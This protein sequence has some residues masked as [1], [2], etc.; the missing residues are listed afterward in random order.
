MSISGG[1]YR[2]FER[3][4][5]TGCT[6]M[7]VFTKNNS[8]WEARPYTPG[9]IEQYRLAAARS[10]V[11]PVLAHAAYLINLCAAVPDVLKKSRA[12]LQ[13]EL[14][15]CEALGILGLI[16]HPGSHVGTGEKEGIKRIAESLNVVHANT[17]KYRTRSILETTAGQ[18]SAVGYRFEQLSG[19]IDYVDEK[20]RVAVCIDTC[21]VF[22]A[23]YDISTESGWNHTIG[24]FDDVVGLRRLAAIHV[25]DSRK[26]LGSRVDRHDHIGKGMIGLEG[27]RML[28][29]DPRLATV[30]KILETE[31]SE[32]MHEDIENMN[33]LRSLISDVT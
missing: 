18:G 14:D 1:M 11:A 32:D 20:D 16:F 25:N 7:Q 28:V 15:R 13:D 10:P 22:A 6:T 26:A 4:A 12:A 8:R 33:V 5:L 9:E 17:P 31:K 30:P 23:G 24:S 27:F 21:H 29:N 3:A 2:A 19:I